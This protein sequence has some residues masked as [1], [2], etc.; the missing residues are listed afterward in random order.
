MTPEVNTTLG[1]VVLKIKIA[2]SN[3]TFNLDRSC[4]IPRVTMDDSPVLKSP[5]VV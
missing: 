5:F 3:I 1:R 4:N 2:P